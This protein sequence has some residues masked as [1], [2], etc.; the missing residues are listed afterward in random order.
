MECIDQCGGLS[1]PCLAHNIIE[2]RSLFLSRKP[3]SSIPS[4]Q[5]SAS[6][7]W[8]SD[9][10]VTSNGQE[11]QRPS[12]QHNFIGGMITDAQQIQQDKF[13][14]TSLPEVPLVKIIN[15]MSNTTPGDSFVTE[16][17]NAALVSYGFSSLKSQS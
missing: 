6:I 10:T 14:F 16:P 1:Q 5:L 15:E 8:F 3:S 17:R 2:S 9:E 4:C 7:S 11:I 12:F 13:L